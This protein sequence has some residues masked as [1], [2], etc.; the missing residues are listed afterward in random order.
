MANVQ[1]NAPILAITDTPSS[2]ITF[3][4]ILRLV[5]NHKQLK[6]FLQGIQFTSLK[7]NEVFFNSPS[8]WPTIH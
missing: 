2:K 4:N 8:K 3:K 1:N 5:T 6:M 7:D